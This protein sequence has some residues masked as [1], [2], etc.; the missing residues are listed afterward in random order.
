VEEEDF[1]KDGLLKGDTNSPMED[2]GEDAMVP[3]LIREGE[4]KV[5]LNVG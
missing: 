1:A 2:A 3:P 5:E 4:A